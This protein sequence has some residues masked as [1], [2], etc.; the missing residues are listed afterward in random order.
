MFTGIIESLGEIKSLKNEGSNVRIEIDS[1]LLNELKVDQ[2]IAHNGVCL[3]VEKIN[4]SSYEVVAVK[5]TIDK[6]NL[7]E[8]LTGQKVNLERCMQMNGRLDGHIVQGH[9]DSTAT[10][11]F[12]VEEEGS[13]IYKF[14][15]Q[16]PSKLIVEK[17]SI[18]IN[19]TSLTAFNVTDFSFEVTII[20]YT[21]DH[22]IFHKLTKGSLV[23]IEFDIVGKYIQRMVQV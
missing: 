1:T 21:Y 14:Q 7:G 11:E 13:W 16:N 20:P 10:V 23:N 18:C 9:V 19:G 5:E 17:G 2:S 8:W 12:I 3:T 6:T 15:L 22:T 4:S